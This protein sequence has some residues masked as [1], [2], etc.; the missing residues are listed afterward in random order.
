MDEEIKK[1]SAELASQ[2]H[3]KAIEIANDKLHSRRQMYIDGLELK[4]DSDVWVLS[5]NAKVRWIE[6]GLEP[7]EMLD[8]I[9][10]SPKAKTSKDG[11]KYLAVPFNHGPGKA[12][13]TPAESNLI[14]TIK[15][16]LNKFN[17]PFGGIEK[18]RTGNPK[19]GLLHNIDISKHPTKTH[20]GPGQGKGPIGEVVQG[21]SGN[22][23]LQGIRVYQ[24]PV[25]DYSPAS[26]TNVKRS[27][28][29]FRMASESQRGKGM[30]EHP[31]LEPTKIMDEALEWGLKQLDEHIVPQLI[32]T[33]TAKL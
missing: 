19:I 32:S 26:T 9:L 30:W 25:P 29:T 11:K 22:P 21:K 13:P 1:T 17:V 28:M 6:D 12:A 16:E 5:L 20:H 18:D 2:V 27:I 8:D 15:T 4:E 33:I 10:S 14:S 7:G 3:L 31:G 24:L 23:Y